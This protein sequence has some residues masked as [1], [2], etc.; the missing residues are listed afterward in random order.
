[1]CLQST[2]H[3]F[4]N[5]IRRVAVFVDPGHGLVKFKIEPDKMTLRAADNNFALRP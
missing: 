3:Q 2:G 4:L 1:M 5:A